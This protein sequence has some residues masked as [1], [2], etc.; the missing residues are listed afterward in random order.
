MSPSLRRQ[1]LSALNTTVSQIIRYYTV[2]QV[3]ACAVFYYFGGKM[4][5]HIL[6]PSERGQGVTDEAWAKQV[7]A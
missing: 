5:S 2:V 6:S 4:I 3:I 7:S 1:T